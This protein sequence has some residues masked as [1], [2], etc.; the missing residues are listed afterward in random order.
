[1]EKTAVNNIQDLYRVMKD[2]YD[3]CG[4]FEIKD[5]ILEWKVFPKFRITVYEEK[6]DFT[7]TLDKEASDSIQ[8]S[9]IIYEELIHRK[10]RNT[11]NLPFIKNLGTSGNVTVIRLNLLAFS[12]LY[13]GPADKCN[14]R[15]RWFLGKY[16]FL[17]PCD[18]SQI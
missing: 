10:K 1:M 12:L 14:I 17:Y 5:N 6:D 4:D 8:K 3:L 9:G 7:V 16:Y 11:D 13:S 2:T 18:S 15:R